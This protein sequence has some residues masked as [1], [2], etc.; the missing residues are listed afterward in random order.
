MYAFSSYYHYHMETIDWNENHPHIHD[1]LGV[2]GAPLSPGRLICQI[3]EQKTA[4]FNK[5][6]SSEVFF[7]VTALPCRDEQNLMSCTF[8]RPRFLVTW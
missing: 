5:S 8:R 3:R 4:Y 6:A 1:F 7:S 2:L